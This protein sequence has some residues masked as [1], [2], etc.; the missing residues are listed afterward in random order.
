MPNSSVSEFDCKT[1]RK[2]K[3]DFSS[4]ASLPATHSFVLKFKMCVLLPFNN[5]QSVRLWDL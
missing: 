2:T 3:K 1:G 5:F 4:E